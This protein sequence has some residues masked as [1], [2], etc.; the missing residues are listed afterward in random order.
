MDNI[1]FLKLRILPRWIIV[2]MDLAILFCSALLA[3]L[4][5]F[6]FDLERFGDFNVIEGVLTFAFTGTV[7]GLATRSYAGIIRYTGLQD[8]GRI[9]TT[10]TLTFFITGATGYFIFYNYGYLL[11]PVSVLIIAYLTSLLFLFSYRLLVKEIFTFFL[12]PDHKKANVII[13]GSNK[14]A[15]TTRH[16]LENDH[17]SRRRVVAYVDHNLQKI[18]KVI[19]GLRIYDARKDLQRLFQIHSVRELII[20]DKTLSLERKN[21]IVDICLVSNVK[22]RTIP[23]VEHWIKGELSIKQIRDINIEELLERESIRLNNFNIKHEIK[24][25]KVMV[26]GAAGSIGSELVRQVLFYRASQII[27]VDQAESDL[28]DVE[29]EIM[30]QK[31]T[32]EVIPVLADITNEERMDAVFEQYKPDII[33]HAAAYKHVPMME[34][35]PAEA[36][37]CNIGGTK[38]LADLA[39]KYGTA[40]FIMVSTD[41]A[42]NPSNVMGATKRIAEIY[43]QS[44]NNF[45]HQQNPEATGFITTRF[46]NVLG[47]KGSV[48]PLFKKQIEKGGPVT[49]THPDIKRYFMT[50]PEACQLVLEAAAM[51]KGGEIFVFD[52]GKSIRIVDLAKKMILLSGFEPGR[53]ID[54]QFSGLRSGEKLYEELLNAQENTLPTYHHKIMIAKTRED[55][56]HVAREQIELL[57]NA[58]LDRDDMKLVGIMKYLVPEFRSQSSPFEALDKKQASGGMASDEMISSV[59]D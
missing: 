26:T 47:S 32:L 31:G 52:M 43:V 12:K 19:N 28:F 42:V 17:R 1:F 39:V 2:L 48:I 6:N 54:I 33:F 21:Q 18:G 46:G 29:Q 16:I 44:L 40:K 25:K 55:D 23:P 49:V 45:I 30:Y 5:R 38:I 27:M 35:N 56:Y 22:V 59:S 9:F 20:S 34:R 14:S 10:A 37:L 58:A 53:D 7:I 8:A 51:G 11:I 15:I 57:L 4:L 3:Y 24:G 13:Y 50:I 36:T 41:K